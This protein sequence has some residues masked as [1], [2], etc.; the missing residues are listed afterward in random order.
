LPNAI[1]I[2]AQN[3]IFVADAYNHRVQVLRYTGKE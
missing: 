2:N 1:A 3:E